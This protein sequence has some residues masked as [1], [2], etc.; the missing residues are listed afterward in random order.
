MPIIFD[1][2]DHP[3][4]TTAIGCLPLLVSPIIRNLKV[5]KMLVNSGAGLNLISSEVISK[6]Q[7]SEEELET[8]ST[9]QG[10]NPGRH[11]PKGKIM[12]PVMFGRELNYQTEK[13]V[14][15]V[16]ELP[17][18]YNGILGHP[19]LAKFMAASHYAYNNCRWGPLPMGIISIPSDKKDAI[20]CVDK[21]Y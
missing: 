3:D 10:I 20:I 19:A 12:L 6:L 16:V 5:T 1:E 8:T 18:P 11:R 7:I 17:L 13:V 14:F 4:R 21:M 15:D 2:E 9:F